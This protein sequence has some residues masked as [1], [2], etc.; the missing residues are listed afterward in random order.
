ME[1]WRSYLLH[2]EFIIHTDQKSLVHLNEQRLNTPWQQRV[3]TKLLGLQYKIVYKQ[4]HENRVADALSRRNHEASLLSIY[5][6]SPQW[7]QSVIEDYMMDDSAKDM[8]SKLAVNPAAVP[9][10]TLHDGLLWF[11]GK[12]WVGHNYKLQQLLIQA[13]HSSAVGGTPAFQ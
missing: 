8:L 11:K 1:Q 2:G 13:L 12:I 5:V 4:D 10:F 6:C 3:F 7:C 9:Y